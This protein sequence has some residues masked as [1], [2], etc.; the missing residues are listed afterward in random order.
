MSE[1]GAHVATELLTSLPVERFS[2][3]LLRDRI[4]T[5]RHDL[6]AYDAAYVA[7]AEALGAP[8]W[9][10]DRKLMAANHSARVRV[11]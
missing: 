10:R 2:H 8:L 9:T 11:F 1:H 7:L 5:L 3:A 6:T 4:W